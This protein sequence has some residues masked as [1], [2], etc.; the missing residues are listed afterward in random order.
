[1]IFYDLAAIAILIFAVNKNAKIGFAQTVTALV[2][3]IAAFFVSMFIGKAFSKLIYE[4]F[5]GKKVTSLLSEYINDGDSVS[6]ILAALN[7]VSDSLPSFMAN[8]YGISNSQYL[9]NKINSSV[10]NVIEFLEEQ[11]VQPAVTGFI[12]IIL[13]VISFA[14]LSFLVHHFSKAVGFVFKLPL[15]KTVDRF[16]GGLLGLVQGGINLY[17]VALAARFILYFLSEQPQFFNENLIM[18]TFIWSRIYL[19]NPFQFLK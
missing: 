11:I 2:G 4:V 6:E 13:F 17:L 15:I 1:M 14:I 5:I 9:E 10:A 8:F 16:C 7:E 18:D 19:F 3:K 12:H